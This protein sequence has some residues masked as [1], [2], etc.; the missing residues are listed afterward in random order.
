MLALKNEGRDWPAIASEL[1]GNADSLRRKLS[2]A[3][4]RVAKQLG[5]D[6]AP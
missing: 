3:L 4:D 1:G 2:R 5:L 6:S